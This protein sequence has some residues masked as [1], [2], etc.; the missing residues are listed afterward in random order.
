M[1]R[2][3]LSQGYRATTRRQYIAREYSW[4]ELFFKTPLG[5]FGLR[6]FSEEQHQVIK[7]GF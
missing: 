4:P 7:C 1:D 2:V 5:V 6:I 3:Q